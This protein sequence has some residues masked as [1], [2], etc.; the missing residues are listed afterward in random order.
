[1]EAWKRV[2][3]SRVTKVGWRKITTKTFILPDGVQAEFD[4]LHP[5]GQEFVGVIPVTTEQ[6]VVIARQFR[7]GPE[8]IMDELPGGFVDAG[9]TPEAAARRELLEE[10]GYQPG[11]VEYLGAFHKDT[12]M[13]A[14]WHIFLATDCVKVTEPTP[15]AHEHIEV[16]EITI[17]QLFYNA[18]HDRVTDHAG[19]LMA[20]EKLKQ[21]Q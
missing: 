4:I 10:T 7:P 12:Y 14:I 21:L 5:D 1:M 2:E 19:I 9:E 15:E 18:T 17:D 3:P 6:K 11:D 13:N 20:Y 8:K 16:D